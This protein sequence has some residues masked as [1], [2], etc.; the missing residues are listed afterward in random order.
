M[1]IGSVVRSAQRQDRSEPT[2]GG[3]S[4]GNRRQDWQG[5]IDHGENEELGSQREGA[6]PGAAGLRDP[7]LP[8]WI[9]DPAEGGVAV[10]LQEAI[11][12]SILPA[13]QQLVLEA[14]SMMERVA[15]EMLI[16]ALWADCLRQLK[17]KHN[18]A[19]AIS[20]DPFESAG[21]VGEATALLGTK[22]KAGNFLVKVQ[23]VRL[24]QEAAAEK[25]NG[26]NR[27]SHARVPSP[28]CRPSCGARGFGTSRGGPRGGWNGW[29]RG[30]KGGKGGGYGGRQHG[31]IEGR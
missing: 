22:I 27:E 18:F 31:R 10:E 6:E 21:V 12:Q 28:I 19:K 15:G 3:T 8:W 5:E 20:D 4:S 23:E 14:P 25:R 17:L 24:K 7:R 11:T 13:H 2:L 26:G 30:G 29:K 1:A 9:P 16:Q